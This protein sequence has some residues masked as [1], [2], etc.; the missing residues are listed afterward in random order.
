M[1]PAPPKEAVKP[2]VGSAGKNVEAA[3]T[4]KREHYLKRFQFELIYKF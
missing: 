1:P 4:E 2:A 3:R